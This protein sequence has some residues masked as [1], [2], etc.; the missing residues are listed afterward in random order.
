M[1]VVTQNTSLKVKGFQKVTGNFLKT[2]VLSQPNR[3]H[4]LPVLTVDGEGRPRGHGAHVVLSIA[5]VDT[6]VVRHRLLHPQTLVLQDVRPAHG[7][8]AVV[9]SPQDARLG[10]S[11][12][13]TLEL[14]VLSGHRADIPR[15][16]DHVRLHCKATR[17][18]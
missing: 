11:A 5:Y 2:G 16:R 1:T 7:H 18:T 17:W 15:L 8:L 4:P 13:S 12:H 3:Q 6:L 14:H 10:V 9:A